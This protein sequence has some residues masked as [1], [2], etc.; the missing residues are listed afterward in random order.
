MYK[1]KLA[2]MCQFAQQLPRFL[3]DMVFI[4]NVIKIRSNVIMREDTNM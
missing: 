1:L 2:L 3:G 4:S